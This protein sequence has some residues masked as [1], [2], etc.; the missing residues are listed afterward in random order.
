M[1]NN[2]PAVA[3]QSLTSVI[4]DLQVER[5]TNTAVLR[6]ALTPC[7]LDIDQASRLLKRLFASYKGALALRLWNGDTLRL[8]MA[9]TE[10]PSPLFTLVFRHPGVVRAMVLGRDPLRAGF[11]RQ[12]PGG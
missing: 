6:S 9:S 7:D 3:A 11:P 12:F 5:L 8:G 1:S 10:E 2:L 4:D